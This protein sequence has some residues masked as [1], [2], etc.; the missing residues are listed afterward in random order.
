MISLIVLVAGGGFSG[1]M[2]TNDPF[3]KRKDLASIPVM[4]VVGVVYICLSMAMAVPMAIAGLAIRRWKP[5]GKTM[6]LVV[7]A[8]GMLH[9]PLGTGVGIYSVWVLNDEATEFL[10]ANEPAKWRR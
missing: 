10:F 1:L 9:F 3:Y 8:V 7:A 5:W 4:R 2:L 6:G